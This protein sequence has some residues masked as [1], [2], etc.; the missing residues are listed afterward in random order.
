MKGWHRFS[1]VLFTLVMPGVVC[2][3]YFNEQASPGFLVLLCSVSFLILGL[4]SLH[5]GHPQL[6][7]TAVKHIQR[8]WLSR[9]MLLFTL[10]LL[11]LCL[12]V[13]FPGLTGQEFTRVLLI[14]GVGGIVSTILVYH[15]SPR[16]GRWPVWIDFFLEGMFLGT[17]IGGSHLLTVALLGKSVKDLLMGL[18][19]WKEFRIWLQPTFLAGIVMIVTITGEVQLIP[20]ALLNSLLVRAAFFARIDKP[21][22]I[23][24]VEALREHYMPAE[25]RKY[26]PTKN[27]DHH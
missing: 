27:A 21:M 22:L 3:Y 26:F 16:I 9:E 1:L 5:L 20:L 17:I 6:A 12:Q 11:G 25:Y 8:S 2:A 7:P 18:F 23:Q 19:F 15:K 13:L 24:T 14:L 4:V 10:F